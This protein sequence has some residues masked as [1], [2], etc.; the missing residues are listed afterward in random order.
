[1][2]PREGSEELRTRITSGMVLTQGENCEIRRLKTEGRRSAFEDPN[3]SAF[4]LEIASPVSLFS[5]VTRV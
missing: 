3:T 5:Q 4:S 2:P 1:V